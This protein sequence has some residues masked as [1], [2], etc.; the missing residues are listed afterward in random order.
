MEN[1]IVHCNR[2]TGLTESAKVDLRTK[3]TTKH[4]AK[5]HYLLQDGNTCKYLFFINQGLAKTFFFKEDKEFIMRFFTESNLFTVVDSFGNQ[6]PSGYAVV[7]LEDTSY[8]TL[9]YDDLQTLCQRHHCMETFF[10]K[11]LAKAATHMMQR[12]TEMLEDNPAER[13]ARFVTN[14]Q[15]LLQRITLG[16]LASYLGITQVSLSRIRARK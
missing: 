2:L 1:F 11:L 5:G 7:A 4:I 12:I 6:Q 9:S 14:N 13:Y 16:D 15:A 8:T 10:S 3:L